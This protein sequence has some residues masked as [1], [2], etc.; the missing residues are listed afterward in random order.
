MS[1]SQ[2]KSFFSSTRI[3]LIALF[4]A[5]SGV[6]YVFGF[7]ISVAFPSFLE[8]NFSDIPALI[9]TFTLGP[10]SGALI[11]FLKII[12]K[13]I[14]KPTSTAFVGELADLLIGLAFVL[15][16]GFVYK[17]KHTFKGALL[18]MLS[19]TAASVAVAVLANRFILV[20]FYV[21]FFFG[22]SWEPIVGMMTPLFP[23]CT[24]ATFY[25]FYLWVSVLPFNIMRCVIASVVTLI[26]YKH[27]SRALNR[28][29]EKLS[30]KRNYGAE[31]AKWRNIGAA[32]NGVIVILVLIL[33]MLS[34]Y[35]FKTI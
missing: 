11:V 15:P 10:V 18:A 35:V 29:N 5:L 27:I 22:G 2:Q 26:V 14:F 12:V 6:L 24:Q 4:A 13:L 17:K 28:L 33:V 25:S 8:L 19:G 32:L 20:P 16:A 23:S 21:R 1:V 31:E 34:V 9:G 7:P 30:L 3:A